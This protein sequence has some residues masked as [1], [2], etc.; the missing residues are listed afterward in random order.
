MLGSS[1]RMPCPQAWPLPLCVLG[2]Q[3]WS[4]RITLSGLPLW[5][6]CPRASQGLSTLSLGAQLWKMEVAV[7]IWENYSVQEGGNGWQSPSPGLQS[8]LEPFSR[9]PNGAI[10]SHPGLLRLAPAAT[11]Y[12]PQETNI[13]PESR[14][15]KA[16][17]LFLSFPSSNPGKQ[18][19]V[20]GLLAADHCCCP[21]RAL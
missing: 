11:P 1:L 16:V 4:L 6:V 8:S 15:F 14:S 20:C 10:R 17:T 7:P 19:H 3:L 12:Y 9:D 2:S 13:L 21:A 18:G 5:A